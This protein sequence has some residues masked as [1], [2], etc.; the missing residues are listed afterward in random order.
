M[1]KENDE[2]ISGQINKCRYLGGQMGNDEINSW[3]NNK[4]MDRQMQRWAD[5]KMRRWEDWAHIRSQK[6]GFHLSSLL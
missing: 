2:Q 5:G 4:G 1:K 3:N 6:D